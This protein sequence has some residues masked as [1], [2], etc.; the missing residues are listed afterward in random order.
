MTIKDAHNYSLPVWRLPEEE[1][2]LI[3][4]PGY[5]RIGDACGKGGEAGVISAN[6]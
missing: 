4:T 2:V 3:L 5:A 6:P 1:I